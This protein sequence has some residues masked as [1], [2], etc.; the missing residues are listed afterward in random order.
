MERIFV[1]PQGFEPRQTAP[2]TGVLPLH[3][4][5]VFFGNARKTICRPT[6]IRTPTNGTKN[7]CATVTP[8]V[9]VFLQCKYRKV[10]LFTKTKMK[11]F[12]VLPSS[13]SLIH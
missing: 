2:K 8:W 10:F 11:T 3:H 1:D 9:F 4:E 13:S 7:R 6:G 5:S 12:L